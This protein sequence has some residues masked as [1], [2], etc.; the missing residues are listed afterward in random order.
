MVKIAP[1]PFHECESSRVIDA[2]RASRSMRT[3]VV[4]LPPSNR[5]DLVLDA[6]L[7]KD[8][9]H[10]VIDGRFADSSLF[11][12][13][14]IWKPLRHVFHQPVFASCERPPTNRLM[15]SNFSIWLSFR[16]LEL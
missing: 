12:D 11:R 8:A 4:V 9:G 6:Q 14:F 3:A 1:I 2:C 16:S 5:F 13:C 10:H 15:A 7:F